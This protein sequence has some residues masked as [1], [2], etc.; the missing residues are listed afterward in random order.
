MFLVKMPSESGFHE[1]DFRFETYA[2]ADEFLFAHDGATLDELV[3]TCGPASLGCTF[4]ILEMA[5]P[6]TLP[7]V[8]AR[9]TGPDA[10]ASRNP[11]NP[12]V[13]ARPGTRSGRRHHRQRRGRIWRG[14]GLARPAASDTGR[15]R[16]TEMTGLAGFIVLLGANVG[17]WA[18][19]RSI[20]AQAVERKNT[21]SE[22]QVAQA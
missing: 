3:D 19:N 10:H 11:A 15:H 20:P 21:V 8:H 14:V 7:D 22:G 2:G 5:S 1:L 6:F 9:T 17:L 4:Y 16:L 13:L 18:L 12:P